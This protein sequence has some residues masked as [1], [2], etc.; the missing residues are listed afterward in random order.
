MPD[1][2][3]FLSNSIA[4]VG[5]AALCGITK[6]EQHFAGQYKIDGYHYRLPEFKKGS[7]LL[8]Q[9]DSITDMKW[10]RN[11]TDRNHYL[12][13]SYVYL[14]A[15]RL[16]V[17][18][19]DAQLDLYNRGMSGHTVADLRKRWQKDAI[20]MKP[21][22]LSI[23]IGTNDVGHGVQADA[24]EFDYR[25]ILDASRKANPELRIVLL[26]P[27]VLQSGKLKDEIAWATRRAATDKLGSVVA[28]LARDYDA[29]HIKTQRIFDA[30]AEDV[31]PEHWIWDGIHPLPQGHELI[32][33]HWIQEVSA[34]WPKV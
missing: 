7:R 30:A 23:L 10:G 13:H 18:L 6:A 9:G 25:H 24:F 32:A 21:D 8:F 2:R 1:R 20:A 3:T 34:R 14:L 15:A 12:G 4:V 31:S 33:R 29:V 26:D 19:A 22:L 27:F 17:E 28:R 5:T 11:Q 16:G